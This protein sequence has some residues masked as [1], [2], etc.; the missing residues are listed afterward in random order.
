MRIALVSDRSSTH[1]HDLAAALAGRGHEVTVYTRRD[2]PDVT[3]G[4]GYRVVAVP[5]GPA[6]SL[7]DADLLT[8]MEDFTD[9]VRDRWAAEPPDV[10]HAHGWLGG[11]A[12]TSAGHATGVPVAQTFHTLTELERRRS[13]ADLALA[14]GRPDAERTVAHDARWVAAACTD[15]LR[16]VVRMGVPTTAP[17]ESRSSA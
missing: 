6:R 7:P 10:A 1:V 14:A 13:G 12:A 16:E 5:A 8:H 17:V 2:N 11:L 4:D 15:E 3:A 9:F